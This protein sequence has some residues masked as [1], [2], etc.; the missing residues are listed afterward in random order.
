MQNP[1]RHHVLAQAIETP[2]GI[3]SFDCRSDGRA[4]MKPSVKPVP[5]AA[6]ELVDR[7]G[8]EAV[9]VARMHRD[10]AQEADDAAGTA[11]W[12]AILET[13]QYLLEEDPR[14]VS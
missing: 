8:D 9:H 2:V 4:T 11:Y 5:E 7:H 10:E 3:P 14:R 6:M 1:S 13:L 12:N